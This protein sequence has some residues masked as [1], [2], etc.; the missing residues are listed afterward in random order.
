VSTWCPRVIK[1]FG[2]GRA[3]PPSFSSS[4][5]S[6]A[7]SGSW[8]SIRMLVSSE[9]SSRKSPPLIRSTSISAWTQLR[10][11]C[12][13]FWKYG[14]LVISLSSFFLLA[15]GRLAT[16]KKTPYCGIT[17]DMPWNRLGVCLNYKNYNRTKIVNSSRLNS[18]LYKREV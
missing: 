16:I 17:A 13:I 18:N 3:D 5:A 15:S 6:G 1:E 12:N 14:S 10:N 11:S 4:S 7:V 8:K 9:A 2:G